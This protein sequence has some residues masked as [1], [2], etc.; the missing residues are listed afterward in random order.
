[1][2]FFKRL[3]MGLCNSAQTFQRVVEH[4]LNDLEGVFVYLDDIMVF[5][6]EATHDLKLE[7]IFKHL[8]DA[9]L[10]K[11]KFLKKKIDYLRYEASEA[12]IR[13]LSKKVEAIKKFLI[14][15]K[16]KELLHYL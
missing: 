7:A 5:S 2:Y 15:T 11:C 13:P 12:G 10:S 4:V 16:Q 3:A 6:E 1:M 8:E 14:P 9:G